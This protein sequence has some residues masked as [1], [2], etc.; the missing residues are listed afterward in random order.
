MNE[1]IQKLLTFLNDT[2]DDPFLLFSLA[3]EYRSQ[4]MHDRS[5]ETYETLLR[6]D[7][8]YTG[9]YYHLG[10]LHQAMGSTGKALEIYTAGIEVAIAA[11][12]HHAASELRAA[13]AAVAEDEG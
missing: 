12:D 1:R 9:A 7:P 6:V 3:Q 10:N 8:G 13:L 11:G 5:F 2:P 4:G